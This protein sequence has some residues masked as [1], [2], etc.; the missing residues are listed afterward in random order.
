VNDITPRD[1]GIAEFVRR[2]EASAAAERANYALFLTQLCDVLKAPSEESP[3]TAPI[4][5][6]RN[7]HLSRL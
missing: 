2:W 7:H 4:V 3:D 6:K 1:A 5:L